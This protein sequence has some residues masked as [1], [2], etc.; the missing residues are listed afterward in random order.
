M[1]PSAKSRFQF[2]KGTIRTAGNHVGKVGIN[3]F[4]FHKGTIR[5]DSGFSFHAPTL[6]QFH[7]G[8][9]RTSL[10]VMFHAIHGY[11][12][13]INVRLEPAGSAVEGSS[14]RFQFHKGTIRTRHI[15]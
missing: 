8:T 3:V 12:N 7:K 1:R 14:D 10:G 4:Q 15:S 5:T 11:F 13:S 6:F 9:I 2:H